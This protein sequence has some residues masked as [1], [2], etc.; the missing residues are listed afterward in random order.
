MEKWTVI[1]SEYLHESPFGNVRRD[2]CRLSNGKEIHDYIIHEYLNWGNV[3]AITKQHELVL[4]KQY[5]HG[6][7]DFVYELPAGGM[8]EAEDPEQAAIRELREETGYT[9]ARQPIFLGEYG[10]NPAACT[11]KIYSYLLLDCEQ[12]ER[13]ELDETEE[14]E[15]V[16][17]PFAD[18]LRFL[19][20][21]TSIQL[22]SIAALLLAKEKLKE[23]GIKMSSDDSR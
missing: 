2:H 5:R 20:K 21:E 19:Q 13:Q 9:S 15:V 10:V 7:S 6:L 8:A 18:A 14:L 16:L 23:L 12:S 22:F 1:R 3:V 4:V 17:V 11:N